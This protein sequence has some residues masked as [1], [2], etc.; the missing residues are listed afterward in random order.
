MQLSETQR[1]ILTTA[2][3]RKGGLV[4]PTTTKLKGGALKQVLTSL[5]KQGLVQEVPAGP[6][7]ETWRTGEDGTRL[8][9]KVT[10]A[11]S[12]T[13]FGSRSINSCVSRF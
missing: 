2:C 1:Q 11:G 10:K 5:L 8:T 4:L 7:H 3:Q 12:G 9:L 13:S 6:K